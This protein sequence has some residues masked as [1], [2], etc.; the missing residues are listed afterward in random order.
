M[1]LL[2]CEML[3]I[4]LEGNRRLQKADRRVFVFILFLFLI[5]TF[6]IWGE[7]EG[8]EG[9][10]GKNFLSKMEFLRLYEHTLNF[11]YND[12]ERMKVET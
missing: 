2:H 6:Y 8:N 10:Q 3:K 12:I 5:L 4:F 11:K 7:W 1:D 9:S